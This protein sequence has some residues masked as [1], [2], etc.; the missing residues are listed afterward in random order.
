VRR[1]LVF[2]LVLGTVVS[3][4]AVAEEQ[5][6]K[7]QIISRSA[8]ICKDLLDAVR[9]HLQKANDAEAKEQWD[10]FIR[11]ARRAIRAA[12][13][14]GHELRGLRPRTGARRYGR[15]VDHGRAALNWLE[16]AL[17]ALE[18]RR[19]ELAESRQQIAQR[20][21]RRARRAAKRYG[22]RRP[23]IRMVS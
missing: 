4:T 10:R 5:L 15:F 9:P 8:P 21:F 1:L 13:P 19:I 16:L 6:T 11:E 23:C 12:R 7:Q 14:Y 18:A 22:L 3:S 17:D 20:H 2:S